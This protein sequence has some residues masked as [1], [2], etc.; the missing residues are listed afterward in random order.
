MAN[1]TNQQAIG[2]YWKMYR[3]HTTSVG[4]G[5]RSGNNVMPGSLGTTTGVRT[6][7]LVTN[8]YFGTN[9][10]LGNFTYTGIPVGTQYLDLSVLVSTGYWEMGEN[11][12][13]KYI[14]NT[15]PKTGDTLTQL[16]PMNVKEVGTGLLIQPTNATNLVLSG[17][18][19]YDRKVVMLFPSPATTQSFT[20]LSKITSVRFDV[21]ATATCA[22]SSNQNLGVPYY[23]FTQP[24][25]QSSIN[26]I[27][28]SL[29]SLAQA[30]SVPFTNFSILA[31]LTRTRAALNYAGTNIDNPTLIGRYSR[32]AGSPLFTNGVTYY[33]Q[34]LQNNP[35][36]LGVEEN[37][38]NPDISRAAMGWYSQNLDK[39]KG[40]AT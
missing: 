18:D 11:A 31:G 20:A 24:N 40:W 35:T 9:A 7:N 4:D 2:S 25:A 5:F 19:L 8:S 39:W 27:S 6:G 26:R 28:G 38:F 33:I 12:L 1:I 29:I 34:M 23:T 16:D 14:K 22:F 21:S 15:V 32:I 13:G 30:N 37:S 3:A 36:A 17:Y 10:R